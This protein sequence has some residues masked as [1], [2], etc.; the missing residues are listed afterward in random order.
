MS[1]IVAIDKVYQSYFNP[2]HVGTLNPRKKYQRIPLSKTDQGN[3]PKISLDSTYGKNTSKRFYY[4]EDI[5]TSHILTIPKEKTIHEALEVMNEKSIHHLL[6]VE[7]SLIIGLVSKSDLHNY[8]PKQLIESMMIKKVLLCLKS[9][10]VKIV[11]TVM[12]E[13]K[14]SCI[15]IVDEDYK[16]LGIITRTNLLEFIVKN[17]PIQM[18]L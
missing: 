12:L 8:S 16:L 5:M 4:V 17:M 14:I 9:T 1:L 13:E 10:Q 2:E 7:D 3:S 18:W 15:P 11:A 6:V